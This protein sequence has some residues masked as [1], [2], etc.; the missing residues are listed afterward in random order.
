MLS[1]DGLAFHQMNRL[2]RFDSHLFQ[3][4]LKRASFWPDTHPS[5]M[6]LDQKCLTESL[7]KL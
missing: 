5:W 6:E 2:L 1:L 4:P 3:R 7:P